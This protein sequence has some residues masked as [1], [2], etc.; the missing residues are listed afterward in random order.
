MKVIPVYFME[1]HYGVPSHNE[2]P[3]MD[4]LDKLLWLRK[5]KAFGSQ[6]D[7]FDDFDV[8]GWTREGD[9]GTYRN[10]TCG[11]DY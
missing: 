3:F 7:Y 5:E 11:F 9:D 4:I 10:R 8:V 2:K 6:N 1:D